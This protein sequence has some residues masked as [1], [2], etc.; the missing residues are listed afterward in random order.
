MKL[1]EIM[2]IASLFPRQQAPSY[3][4]VAKWHCPL[5]K[6]IKRKWMSDGRVY[7]GKGVWLCRCQPCYQYNGHAGPWALSCWR[8]HALPTRNALGFSTPPVETSSTR[9]GDAALLQRSFCH[10]MSQKEL[11]AQAWGLPPQRHTSM[12]R[13]SLD[14]GYK[15]IANEMIS[16]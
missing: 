3:S 7:T 4:C 1:I 10:A 11:N 13:G 8:Y 16:Y 6:N 9:D 15:M 14:T 5:G 12:W 2:R